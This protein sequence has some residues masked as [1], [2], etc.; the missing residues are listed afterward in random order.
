MRRSGSRVSIPKA[1]RRTVP[2]KALSLCEIPIP[3]RTTRKSYRP[4]ASDRS[5]CCQQ[6]TAGLSASGTDPRRRYSIKMQRRWKQ[7][8]NEGCQRQLRTKRLSARRGLEVN[9]PFLLPVEGEIFFLTSPFIE[10]ALSLMF[11]RGDHSEIQ[12][13]VPTCGTLFAFVTSVV[14]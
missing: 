5:M 13:V 12:K 3:S 1:C 9:L 10:Q 7:K 6:A 2:H 8:I 11:V 14:I 4:R